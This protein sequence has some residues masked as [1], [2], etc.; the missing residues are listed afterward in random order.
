[1]GDSIPFPPIEVVKASEKSYHGGKNG[2]Y[3]DAPQVV[4]DV[5]ELDISS[6][7]PFAMKALPGIDKGR[8]CRVECYKDGYAGIYC[9]TGRAEKA[10]GLYPLVFDHSFSPVRGDF[11]NLW[12][13]GHELKRMLALKW[14]VKLEPYYGYV[15]QPGE[16]SY[17]PFARFV[18]HFYGKKESTPKSDPY[19]HLYKIVLNALYGKLASTIEVKSADAE[20]EIKKL[21]LMGVDIPTCVR[22]DQRYDK[23]LGRYVHLV[24]SWRAGALYNP[25]LASQITGHARSYLYDLEKSHSSLHSATD[26]IKT[27]R[28]VAAVKGLGG[29]KIECYGRCYLFRNKLYLHFSKSYDHC[30]HDATHG[31]YPFRYPEKYLDGTLH[32]KAG[33][34]LMDTDGQHL[35]KVGLH[36]YKGPLWF[37]FENRHKLIREGKLKYT[38]KHVVGLREGLR[39]GWTPC[40]FID[41]EET[42][43]LWKVETPDNIVKFCIKRGGFDYLRDIAFTGE[44]NMFR[45]K[46]GGP[47]AR[48]LVNLHGGGLTCDYMR[49]AC[50]E[51]GY[52]TED[53]TISDLF[54]AVDETL[55]GRPVYA[56]LAGGNYQPSG[57]DEIYPDELD[58]EV[59]I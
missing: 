25:F 58:L 3:L 2:F 5:Y 53:A 24:K 49:E 13:T 28:P 6:A 39:R 35:C 29:L 57:L 44:L 40:D 51:G 54:D 46:D 15:W 16:G 19:Y 7:Y 4:E 17:N 14:G 38:Y 10:R 47:R 41:I 26:S 8:Y 22:I 34:P 21:R 50:V 1:M 55:R 52:L 11:E 18:D 56:K 9:L 31:G 43:S 48:G 59:K 27:T 45:A 42:L 36:G 23:L 33:Q 20:D 12:H 37:L 32:P 30:Q